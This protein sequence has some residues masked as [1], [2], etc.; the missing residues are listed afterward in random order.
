MNN[1]LFSDFVLNHKIYV[2]KS[3][4]IS[5]YEKYELFKSKLL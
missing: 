1:N 5:D 3:V 4:D 2:V